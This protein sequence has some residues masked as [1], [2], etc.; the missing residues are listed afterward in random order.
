MVDS[1]A[2]CLVTSSATSSLR[3]VQRRRRR[4]RTLRR[5]SPTPRSNREHERAA[6]PRDRAGGNLGRRCRRSASP[7][8]SWDCCDFGHLPPTAEPVSTGLWRD[9]ADEI[10]D[11]IR[12]SSARSPSRLPASDDA[13]NVGR[14]EPDDSPAGGRRR[15]WTEDRV[16][17]VL[18]HEL[19]HILRGDWVVALTASA[20]HGGLLVQPA[21][22]DRVPPTATRRRT[23]VRR[24]RARLRHQRRRSTQP[25]CST[26]RASPRCADIPGHRQLPSPI[27][28]CSKGEFVPCSTRAS[29]VTP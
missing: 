10:V 14:A 8:S 24:P 1:P 7:C 11:P 13:R 26:S 29:I 18:H 2:R 28:R 22:L 15:R 23:C 21:A 25:I 12:H 6:V 16:Q 27:T 19:A 3:F 5:P 4:R 20:A 9:V 17:A